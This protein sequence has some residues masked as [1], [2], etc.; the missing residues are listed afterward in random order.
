MRTLLAVSGLMLALSTPLT[1]QT[2]LLD[3]GVFE[4]RVGGEVIG[5]EEFTI[6]RMGSAT[7]GTIMAQATISH[8][9]SEMRTQ[10]ETS[11][12]WVPLDYRNALTGDS[13]S[14]VVLFV[15][16]RR[17][18]A[19]TTNAQGEGTREFRP[20]ET[21]VVLEPNI[22]FL[23]HFAAAQLGSQLLTVVEPTE[24]R[25]TRLRIETVGP[26]SFKLGDETLSARRIR[27]SSG[28]DVRE[29]VIDD[30]NR[31]LRVEVPAE[32]FVAV[33]ILR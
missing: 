5:R 2:V 30:Q 23:Y 9:G 18:I 3:E 29:L 16:G 11:R 8:G 6:H 19:R 17:L 31:L 21:T 22:A 33:R 27:L 1:G 28:A 32:Q 24:G 26:E 12:Q 13:P 14:E 7:D 10:L 25:Q 15:D 20:G 4:V